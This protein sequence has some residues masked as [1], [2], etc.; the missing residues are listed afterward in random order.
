MENWPKLDLDPLKDN[1]KC[2][3]CGPANPIGLKLKFEWDKNTR[4]A[5]AKFT[6]GENLQGWTGFIHGG[7]TAC[8]LDEAMGRA[9]MSAGTNNVT[10]KMEVRYRRM[11][12]LGQTCTVSCT[13]TKQTSRLIE[14]E[15]KITDMDGVVMAEGN[16]TQFVVSQRGNTPRE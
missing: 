15:A 14:T 6:P 11:I 1:G 4:T 12:P 2:F 16:S 3:G 5:T 9:A 7:I 13:V 8:V 10:A